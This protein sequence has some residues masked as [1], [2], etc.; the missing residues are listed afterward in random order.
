MDLPDF[1]LL[2]GFLGSGKTSLIAEALAQEKFANTG[3]IVN[4]VGE[5]NIDGAVLSATASGLQIATMSN[6][7]VCCSLQGDLPFTVAGLMDANEERGDP[8]LARIILET[9]GLSRPAPILRNLL[10]LPIPFR[11][12]VIATYD[13]TRNILT[14][15]RYE[16]AVAQI[17]GAQT[18]I[19]TKLDCASASQIE[20]SR[21]L[22][23]ALNP[24]AMIVQEPVGGQ[25][26]ELA[27]VQ[28]DTRPSLPLPYGFVATSPALSHE[29]A[30]IFFVTPID[31]H[32]PDVLLWLSDLAGFCGEK[33]LRVKGI[34]RPDSNRPWLLVQSVG[35]V[36][37]QP[38]TI[39]KP[40]TM[41]HGVVVIARDIFETDLRAL[42][43]ETAIQVKELRS[44]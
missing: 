39:D 8:P 21:K 4:E 1:H 18:I 23:G 32:W 3:V 10:G 28:P 36:F 24:F 41:D 19:L 22:V 12:H 17:A 13:C 14:G 11:V 33:L 20:E 31:Q 44:S 9:S 35:T 27:F 5:I 37:D 40:D 2:C 7:C 34:V 6:G 16:E 30:R 42:S 26:S 38:R 29:R 25:R 15:T 43:S